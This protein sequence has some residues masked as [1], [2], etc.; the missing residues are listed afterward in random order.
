MTVNVVEPMKVRRVLGA[1][2]GVWAVGNMRTPS[3]DS[4]VVSES[5]VA[6]VP[7]LLALGKSP[8]FSAG[9]ARLMA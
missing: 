9:I 7:G 8:G 3:G 5:R 4:G 1:A 6:K 2:T